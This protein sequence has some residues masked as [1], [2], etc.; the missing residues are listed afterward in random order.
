SSSDANDMTCLQKDSLGFGYPTHH[1]SKEIILKINEQT[2]YSGEVLKLLSQEPYD[3]CVFQ[4]ARAFTFAFAPG[5]EDTIS[6][7]ITLANINAFVQRIQNMAPVVTNITVLVS[8]FDQSFI[9]AGRHFS[10]MISRLF[11]IVSG[12]D[13]NSDFEGSAPVVLQ[14]ESIRNL[15]HIR[16]TRRNN[17]DPLIQLARLNAPTLQSL[18]IDT[19]IDIDISGLIRDADGNH[20]TYPRLLSLKL[21]DLFV[22]VASRQ[23]EF[24]GAVP[25]PSLRS[26]R[27]W[28]S[29]SLEDDMFFRGNAGTLES[30][31]IKLDDSTFRALCRHKVFAPGSHP[32]LQRVS[33]QYKDMF[34]SQPFATIAETIKFELGIGPRAAVREIGSAPPNNKVAPVISALGNHTCIQVLTILHIWLELWDVIAIIKSLPLLSDL[35]TMSLR[36]G[37]IPAGISRD[38]LPSFM[39]LTYASMGKRFRFCSLRD[40]VNNI[41][42]DLVLCVLLLALACPNFAYAATSRSSHTQFMEMVEEAIASDMFRQYAP[43]LRRL[44]FHKL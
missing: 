24:K 12:V 9:I 35:H 39:L 18:S 28:L 31:D 11:Q 10:N 27:L 21:R 41:D 20:T 3:G 44:L 34:S 37:A 6:P 13:Y 33:V 26:L 1:L 38:D 23:L 16:F 29:H 4:R 19:D 2:V 40:T 14:L 25:F 36:I 32:K 8:Y 15:S 17:L 43:R 22:P 7:A 42:K 30:L 5:Y